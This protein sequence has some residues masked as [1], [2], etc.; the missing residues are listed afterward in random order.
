MK[1]KQYTTHQT[2]QQNSLQIVCKNK[3]QS[4]AIFLSDLKGNI[5]VARPCISKLRLH[6]TACIPP[7]RSPRCRDR[8]RAEAL[9]HSV[10]FV[11]PLWL[12]DVLPCCSSTLFGLQTSGHQQLMTAMKIRGWPWL[13][14]AQAP[15]SREG[16]RV[17]WKG[18]K[19]WAG[20]GMVSLSPGARV[21]ESMKKESG[22][23]C[24]GHRVTISNCPSPCG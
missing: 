5:H 16:S 23:D 22:E 13:H 15:F 21:A 18:W 7:D 11:K 24:A 6:R 20:K 14:S 12:L 2:R 4:T 10:V 3:G 17:G 19:H 9:L 8:G 1:T